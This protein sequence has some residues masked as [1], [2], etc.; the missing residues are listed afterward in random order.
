M[1]K[2][3]RLHYFWP[4][5]FLCSVPA[6]LRDAS[7]RC[8]H[9]FP[10]HWSSPLP[11]ENCSGVFL[12]ELVQTFLKIRNSSYWIQS[13]IGF[14][15]TRADVHTIFE[16]FLLYCNVF[17]IACHWKLYA[18]VKKKYEGDQ[19]LFNKR[20]SKHLSGQHIQCLGD[21]RALVFA[22]RLGNHRIHSSV[23]SHQRLLK[24]SPALPWVA[25]S[26]KGLVG[27]LS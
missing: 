6:M 25:L 5:T 18:F 1:F 4:V 3:A 24:W 13:T 21:I 23:G 26:I 17:Y 11:G 2:T 20:V 16:G 14:E 8:L 22:L 10:V 19:F 9:S 12:E 27:E 15:P 7:G